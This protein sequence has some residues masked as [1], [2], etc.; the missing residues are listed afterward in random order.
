MSVNPSQLIE[1]LS[2]V[3]E[4]LQSSQ[5]SDWTSFARSE[6]IATLDRELRS[7]RLTGE[8]ADASELVFL[9][10]PTAPIQEI[11]MANNWS[12]VFLELSE[13]FDVLI[14]N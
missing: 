13:R 4:R 11:S 5:E 8:L 2:L 9:F 12:K 6:I 10:G 7:L 14:Q 3:R 1:V